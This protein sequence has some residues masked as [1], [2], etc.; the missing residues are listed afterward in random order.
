MRKKQKHVWLWLC[1]F[2]NSCAYK[3][4]T[5]ILHPIFGICMIA[6]FFYVL[7]I[8]YPK[9]YKNLTFWANQPQLPLIQCKFTKHSIPEMSASKRLKE[10][11]PYS[12]EVEFN[13][14][15]SREGN[16]MFYYNNSHLVLGATE[17]DLRKTNS[18]INYLVT[19]YKLNE[20]IKLYGLYQGFPDLDNT[21]NCYFK[22]FILE[23]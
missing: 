15:P 18:K 22:A 1:E 13:E 10:L 11:R 6:G 21:S 5:S 4:I 9:V 20:T 16:I 8:T 19:H 3:L 23:E 12:I 7:S 17:Q 2:T 14:P